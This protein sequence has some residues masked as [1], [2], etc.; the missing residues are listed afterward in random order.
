MLTSFSIEMGDK[1]LTWSLLQGCYLQGVWMGAWSDAQSLHACMKLRRRQRRVQ[2]TSLLVSV[3]VYLW[4]VFA[5]NVIYF[6]LKM[7]LTASHSIQG[8]Y[9]SVHFITNVID[10]WFNILRSPTPY[11][12]IYFTVLTLSR[13]W[14]MYGM[15]VCGWVC[16]RTR[17]CV[18]VCV[19]MPVCVCVCVSV[20]ICG[21]VH[22]Y[23]NNVYLSVCMCPVMFSWSDS[24]A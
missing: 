3:A 5:L 4:W 18:C 7:L 15:Y 17:V 20:C 6:E 1:S 23:M 2:V 16:V 21:C 9:Y 8:V 19:C 22:V 14:T 12:N 10:E 13:C 24:S 11:C